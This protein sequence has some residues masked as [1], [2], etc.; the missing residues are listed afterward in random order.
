MTPEL[1]SKIALLRKRAVEGTL[2]VAD[3]I[4]AAAALRD[5]R[6]SAASAVTGAAT[7]RAKASAPVPS[8]DDLLNELLS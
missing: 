3:M 7:K 2:T 4:E 8:G 5:G 1:Q 6:R